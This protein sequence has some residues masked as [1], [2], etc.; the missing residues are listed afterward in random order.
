MILSGLQQINQIYYPYSIKRAL[1]N[2]ALNVDE[3]VGTGAGL[4]QID[5]AFDY[6]TKTTKDDILNKI[7]FKFNCATKSSARGLYLKSLNEVTTTKDYQIS[8]EPKFFS[9]FKNE[10]K[11]LEGLIDDR[12]ILKKNENNNKFFF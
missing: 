5:K 11:L 8:I 6:L 4:I 9:E 12:F 7:Q 2:T 1:E 10:K 3:F